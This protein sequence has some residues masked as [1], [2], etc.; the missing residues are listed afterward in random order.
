MPRQSKKQQQET[1]QKQEQLQEKEKKEEPQE[2]VKEPQK[3]K[4]DDEQD[5]LQDDKQESKPKITKFI[6]D[7][8]MVT[9]LKFIEQSVEG[10]AEVPNTVR[11]TSK[12]NQYVHTVVLE[13]VS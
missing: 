7:S 13:H 6:P 2:E 5:S 11:L 10:D 9:L 1:E 4:Q 8:K 3:S 12:F